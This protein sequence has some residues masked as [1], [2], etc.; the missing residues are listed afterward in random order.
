MY[1]GFQFGYLSCPL[2]DGRA[3]LLGQVQK[4]ST[5]T[6]MY[7]SQLWDVQLKG[8]GRTPYSRF[9][10]GLAVL[11]S[12]VREYLCSEAMHA[13]GIPTTRALCIVASDQKLVTSSV[14]C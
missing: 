1:S 5:I 7:D 6:G 9:G 4:E 13:L 11:R 10:D 3:L 2:G 14:S 8:C 12:T